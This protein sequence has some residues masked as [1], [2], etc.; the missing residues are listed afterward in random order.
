MIRRKVF[1]RDYFEH[2][3]LDALDS[4]MEELNEWVSKNPTCR[5]LSIQE[6]VRSS[7]EV[8]TTSRMQVTMYVEVP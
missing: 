4:I 7:G 3:K 1:Y 5:V 8:L 6:Y 2:H